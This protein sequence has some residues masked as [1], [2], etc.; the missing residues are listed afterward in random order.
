MQTRL[1]RLNVARRVNNPDT[2]ILTPLPK[3]LQPLF[4]FSEGQIVSFLHSIRYLWTRAPF[5][6]R[7]SAKSYTTTTSL[8]PLSYIK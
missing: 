2:A 6:D 7:R 8:E 1:P 5:D 4:L 3:F